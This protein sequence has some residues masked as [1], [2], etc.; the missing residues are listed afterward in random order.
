MVPVHSPTD[1]AG[2]R[3]GRGDR[4]SVRLETSDSGHRQRVS[5][6]IGGSERQL[7]KFPDGRNV[8]PGNSGGPL[9]NIRGD[10]IGEHDDRDANKRRA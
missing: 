7:Q 6:S 5:R 8:N 2:G 10:V 9:L 1:G 4:L 3:L